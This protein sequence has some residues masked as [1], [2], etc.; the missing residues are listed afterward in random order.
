LARLG[1]F[2]RHP[3]VITVLAGVFSALLIPQIT[4]EWQDRQKEQELKQSLLDVISTDTTTAVRQGISLANGQARAA[5]GQQGEDPRDVYAE[6][7]NS[8]LIHRASARSRIIVYFPGVYACWYSYERAVADYLSLAPSGGAAQKARV[9]D[10]QR[11]VNA[12]FAESYVD[13][14]APDGCA[15]MT[16]LPEVVQTRFRQLKD[17]ARWPALTFPASN[18]RF[19]AVYAIVGEEL[20]IGMERVVATIV[21][22]PAAGFSHGI[23]HL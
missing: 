22:T 14:G 8:W 4:R 7:R 12:D 9:E 19:R 20:L 13:S 15:P 16:R 21:K 18:P 11:Y 2:F 1:Q 10:L 6:L 5:G 3:L 17:A 23:A